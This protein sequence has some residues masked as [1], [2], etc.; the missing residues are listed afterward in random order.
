MPVELF[1]D[2]VRG[3]LVSAALSVQTPLAV[4]ARAGEDLEWPAIGVAMRLH[5][6]GIDDFVLTL[7]PETERISA[8]ILSADPALVRPVEGTLSAEWLGDGIDLAF[9]DSTLDALLESL[10]AQPVALRWSSEMPDG[11]EW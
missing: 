8:T 9:T 11:A 10:P 4:L 1:L 7:H 2:E 3:C 5:D 6:L